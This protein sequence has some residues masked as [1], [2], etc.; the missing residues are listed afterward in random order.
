MPASVDAPPTLARQHLAIEARD[1]MP[2]S[3]TT[4]TTASGQRNLWPGWQTF[5]AGI[6]VAGLLVLL[7]R[8]VVDQ[9]GA[10]RLVAAADEIQ[11]SDWN[12]LLD[13]CR[14]L[15]D[16]ST[17]TKRKTRS[18]TRARRDRDKGEGK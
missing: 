8:L 17:R 7:A 12:R 10:R 16:H 2:V 1:A 6:Y 14:A 15:M 3:E 4:V 13:E 11:D 5:A 9:I 18:S